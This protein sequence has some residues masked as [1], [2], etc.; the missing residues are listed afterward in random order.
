MSVNVDSSWMQMQHG[1]VGIAVPPGWSDSTV[2]SLSSPTRNLKSVGLSASRGREYNGHVS[3]SA[4]D[5][6]PGLTPE[7]YLVGVSDQLRRDGTVF[8][9]VETQRVSMAGTEGHGIIRR[10]QSDGAW[11]RQ[12]Q[13]VAVV[14]GRFVVVTLSAVDG[15]PDDDWQELE[16]VLATLTFYGGDLSTAK[17]S[18]GVQ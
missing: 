15:A 4:F 3:V 12:L 2:I 5:P 6:P 14:E 13:A 7:S 16:A 17:S 8:Q 18:R 11:V 1:R 10:V 9:D